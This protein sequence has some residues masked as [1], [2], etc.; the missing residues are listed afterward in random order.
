MEKLN[1]EA[2]RIY[3]EE[4]KKKSEIDTAKRELAKI[5][6]R[7]EKWQYMF[8][9]GLIGKQDIRKKMAEEDENEKEVRQRIAQEQKS[10][11]G[12]PR[13]EELVGLVE[14]WPYFD[15]REKKELIYTIF[16]KII[17]NT[18]LRNVKG[19]KNKFFD[20]Y[21]HDISFN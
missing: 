19:V 6:E 5:A 10:F 21:I 7:R 9:E 18:D 16:N 4:G 12:I 15:D 11:S 8:V 2:K 13:I 14:G 17:V 1:E 20:A 3:T